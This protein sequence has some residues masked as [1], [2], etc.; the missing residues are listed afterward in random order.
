MRYLMFDFKSQTKRVFIFLVIFVLLFS[1]LAIIG[2]GSATALTVP[3][4]NNG[5]ITTIAGNGTGG[6]SGDGGLAIDAQMGKPN[7]VAMDSAG[8]VFIADN[9]N[10][11][12][13]MVAETT[14][15]YYGI[16]MTAGNIYTVA[17][18]GTN[19][20]LGDDSPATDVQLKSVYGL[21]VDYAGNLYINDQRDYRIRRVN[22]DGIITTVAGDGTAGYS[23]DGGSAASAQLQKVYGL[24]VDSNGNLFIA[25]NSNYCVRV[26]A[27]T[28]GTYY[29]VVMTAGNIYT[30]A[31][32]GTRGYSGDGGPAIS[33]QISSAYDVTLDSSG[34]LY[35]ADR[36]DRRVRRVDPDGV[37]TT[38][39]GDGN[40]GYSGDGSQATDAQLTP[41]SVVV[42]NATNIYIADRN[43]YC[44]R[45]VDP[46]GLITT[47][48][49]GNGKGASGDGGL[50]CIA[51]IKP[52][53]VTI[54]SSGNLYI[55][56]NGGYSVRYVQSPAE[57]SGLTDLTLEGNPDLTYNGTFLSYDLSNLDLVGA[58]DNEAAYDLTGMT[59]LWT[60]K[61]GPAEV[62]GSILTIARG[63]TVEVTAQVLG[64]I[65]NTFSIIVNTGELPVID[66]NVGDINTVA[67]IGI[68]GYDGD[69]EA[70]IDCMLQE[71]EEVA[72][73]SAGNI[74]IA[75]AKSYRIRVVA[76]T[77][78]T[79]YGVPM[80]AGNI[81]TVAG[82]GT[83]GYTGDGGPA[84]SAQLYF[85]Q[86]IAVDNAGNIYICII[87]NNCIRKVD[88]NGII[89][90]VAGNGTDGYSGDGG[91]AA[92]AE[93]SFPSGVAV[94]NAGNIFIGTVNNYRV[95]MVAA[96]TGT[97]FGISVI[98]GNIYTVAGIGSSG[99]SG[100]GGPA[101]SARLQTNGKIIVDS[102]GNLYIADCYNNCIRKVDADG[103]ITTMAGDGT[104]GYAGDNGPAVSAKFAWP[105]N[106][107][108]DD[109]GNLYVSD[110]GNNCVRKV[111]S[112]GIITTVVGDG[113]KGYSGD[114]SPATSAQLNNPRGM[115]V[116]DTD[117]LLYIVDSKNY[118]VRY[119]KLAND[120]TIDLVNLTLSGNPTLSYS[121]DF[122]N[123]DLGELALNGTDQNGETCDLSGQTV[124]WAVHSG[125]AT[126]SESTLIVNGSGSV[127]VSASVYSV[128]SNIVSLTVTDSG[129]QPPVLTA[130][131]TGNFAEQIMEITFTEDTSWR[132]AIR[133]VSV[134]GVALDSEKYSKDSAG[135]IIIN[136]DIFQNER[137]YTIGIKA[138]GYSDASVIQTIKESVVLTV[139]GEGVT[140]TLTFTTSQLQ[141]REQYRHLYSTINKWPTKKWYVGEGIKVKDLLALAGL[142]EDAKLIKFT[143]RDGV[144]A[145]FM[146]QELMDDTRYLFPHFKEPGDGHIPGSIMDAE[147]VES[148]LALQS[149][150][151]DNFDAMD[152][153]KALRLIIGQRAVSEQVN[154]AYIKYINK[155]EV[156]TTAPAKWETPQADVGSGDVTAGTLVTLST[157]DMNG[158]KIYYTMD[159]NTPTF[160]STMY[161]PIGQEWVRSR[162][163]AV[164]N[165]INHP[166]EINKDT[167]I[168]AI[169][170]GPGKED[171]DV[172]TFTYQVVSNATPPV[173]T[174]S[175]VI[176]SAYTEGA[177]PDGINTLTVNNGIPG[178][179]Y[180]A[181]N[182]TPVTSHSGDEAVVFTH[183]RNGTQISLNVTKA[184]FDLVSTA[185]AGFN[186]KPGD[187]IKAYIVDDITNAVDVNPVILQ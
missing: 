131:T 103:I 29:G 147:E 163:D 155:V 92:S 95:R 161:N 148:I 11:C 151:S 185:Q 5:Y 9:A 129:A 111:D 120:E 141:A 81:Y 68:K 60:V 59:T 64:V 110:L 90:T 145:T 73:D 87:G 149:A 181:V 94:D 154:D 140:N 47:V 49:G 17:G 153:R 100:D 45:R 88:T 2:L 171:S 175:P 53:A 98:A 135:K 77:N 52:I 158:D 27:A 127:D 37:I 93:L 108:M 62:N 115:T 13:R 128:A 50:A 43:N 8:N 176:D 15:T 124:S 78:G 107:A 79:H 3:G 19:A 69:G 156:F 18:Q 74:I 80:L 75:D 170:I 58:D 152:D 114:G 55:A 104:S 134:D 14:G 101:T 67:G 12:V 169:A 54:D 96:E 146:V 51:K 33:A 119:V 142:K 177:T 57:A 122:F 106:L 136:G 16:S 186:V 86:G 105:H 150:N 143:G 130:D 7:D 184:D 178:F 84:T 123:Y 71:P 113:T 24:A 183:L 164:V 85:I 6:Y 23:G 10:K 28:S 182:I 34:N 102:S 65:S 44:V 97:K 109:A 157:S 174:V 166:I 30:V 63:G 167:T 144:T 20:E 38:V 66:V 46:S 118:C 138:S 139:T 83:R 137:D 36:S 56:D 125:Q 40:L 32:D 31:G 133:E 173:Y 160:N 168:K 82:T 162:E 126:V 117:H 179:K 159:G 42:D 89:T 35:V 1:F 4:L 165:S 116:D 25:D 172:V 187:V 76:A 91:P 48:A 70:A 112:S 21:A 22:S 72:V 132:E 39:A 121:G 180:F 61:S 26:V 41:Y 99:Y